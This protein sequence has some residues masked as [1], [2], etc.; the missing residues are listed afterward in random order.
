MTITVQPNLETGR[1][2]LMVEDGCMRPMPAGP[3]L[4]RTPKGA[5][6]PDI[7]FIH[8]TRESAEKDAEKLT[9]YL[10]ECG[11]RKPNKKQTREAGA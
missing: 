6:D 4:F 1:F 2:F 11:G 10:A 8:A 5:L 9:R 7:R 3:R